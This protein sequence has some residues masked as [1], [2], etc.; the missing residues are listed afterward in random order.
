MSY[1][2]GNITYAY[3]AAGNR[4]SMTDGLGS[5]AY[6]Y[7]ALNRLTQVAGPNGT[8]TYAYDLNNNRTGVTYPGGN[9]VI[10][11]YDAADRL[12]SVTDW[13]SRVTTYSYDNANR[14][15]NIQYPNGVQAAHAYDIADRLLSIVQTHAT[16][17][18]ITSATYTLDN[19]GN[20]LTMQDPDGTTSYTYDD[21]HRLTQVIYP[22]GESVT[23]TYDAM[24]NRT[25]LVSSSPARQPTATTR[26]TGCSP[27]PTRAAPPT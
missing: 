26:A 9:T 7:D 16:N 12:T 21:L 11:A 17:G 25:S 19:V 2:G 22:N 4:T 15:T 10:S 23:Y 8:L 20:R 27:S 13:G 24:G 14:L 6:T 18:T 3:N 1:P 5:T